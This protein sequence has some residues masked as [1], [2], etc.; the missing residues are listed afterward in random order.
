MYNTR[1]TSSDHKMLYT[2]LKIAVILLASS[3]FVGGWLASL[4]GFSEVERST[5]RPRLAAIDQAAKAFSNKN[6]HLVHMYRSGL[7]NAVAKQS[8]IEAD[9][10][11]Y[12]QTGDIPAEWLRD[13]SAQVRP[14]LYFAKNDKDVRDY[15]RNVIS[16]QAEY[17]LIDPYANAFKENKGVWEQ[18]YELD[19][20]CYPIILAWTYWRVTNDSSIFTPQ[21]QKAMQKAV[22]IMKLE[23]DH[24]KNSKYTHDELTRN[25]KDRPAGVCGMV[26]SGFRPSDDACR[27]HYLIPS[28][29]MAVVAL[30][31]LEQIEKSIYKNDKFAAQVAELKNQIDN[32]IRKYGIVNDKQYGKVFAFEVDGLGNHTLEDDA[33]I[34]SLLSAPYLGYVS[35]DDPIYQN[36]RRLILSKAN[37]NFASGKIASGIGSEHTPKGYIWPLAMVMRGL[38]STDRKEIDQQLKELLACDPGDHLLHES[39]HPD[40]QKEFTRPDFGWPNA[41][42]AEFIMLKYQGKKALPLPQ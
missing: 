42:F 5:R 8:F 22:E 4:P 35:T 29:M 18:K 14:Y 36:T 9:G 19:S 6:E 20:L 3:L 16:R 33:N 17:I 2:D 25:G 23:Q 32:G 26:W 7:S 37:K 21:F 24:D 39:F 40:N 15:L 34:P 38:T 13:S 31:G 28:E 1:A 10:S 41:L 27:Y 30:K 11:I 12:V